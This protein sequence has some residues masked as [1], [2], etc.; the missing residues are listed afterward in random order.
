MGRRA[1]ASAFNMEGGFNDVLIKVMRGASLDEVIT[2]V[3][4]LL[5][6]YGGFGAIPRSQQISH[7]YLNNELRQLQ[8][9]GFLM[10]LVFLGV[11]GFLC[12]CSAESDRLRATRANSCHQSSW[13]LRSRAGASLHQMGDSCVLPRSRPWYRLRCLVGLVADTS[14]R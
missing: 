7:W 6:P 14:L 13:L 8:T 12:Q 1:L 4:E 10:P 11:A 2:R 9:M 5:G 3:D